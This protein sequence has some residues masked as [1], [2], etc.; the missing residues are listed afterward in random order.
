M[1]REAARS[2]AWG[3]QE[4]RWGRTFSARQLLRA[5]RQIRGISRGQEGWQRAGVGVGV[6]DG[7]ARGGLSLHRAEEAKG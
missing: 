6:E 4:W 1:T 5:G 7:S 2:K 3:Q